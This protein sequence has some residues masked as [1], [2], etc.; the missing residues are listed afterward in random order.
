VK[1]VPAPTAEEMLGAIREA[2]GP[3][4]DDAGVSVVEWAKA[5]SISIP[6]A[7]GHLE[8][9]VLAGKLVR[10]KARRPYMDGRICAV[11]VYR[12]A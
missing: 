4:P 1:K 5:N 11:P 9:G 12:P 2:I 8:R 10:G 6:S 7:R 3:I